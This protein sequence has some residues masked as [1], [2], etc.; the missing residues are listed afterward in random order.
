MRN[1]YREAL[2]T[3]L[4]WPLILLAILTATLALIAALL[5]AIERPRR[6]TFDGVFPFGFWLACLGITAA[7]HLREML[8]SPR[9]RVTPG[10]RETHLLVAGAMTAIVG[11]VAPCLI[12]GLT[13]GLGER[14]LAVAAVTLAALTVPAMLSQRPFSGSLRWLIWPLYLFVLFVLFR[15]E[16]P[17]D[18]PVS[19]MASVALFAASIGS[20]LAL[21]IHFLQLREETPGYS[22][23]GLL[24][25]LWGPGSAISGGRDQ[26]QLQWSTFRVRFPH[27]LR[28]LGGK[29]PGTGETLLR[30][31]LHWHAASQVG[32][33]ML[34]QGMFFGAI[35]PV[36][37][38]LLGTR[39]LT[40]SLGYVSDLICLAAPLVGLYPAFAI[41]LQPAVRARVAGEFLRPFSRSQHVQAVALVLIV[42][43]ASEALAIMLFPFAV[44]WL[45]A[46]KPVWSQQPLWPMATGLSA[47]PLFLGVGLAN[48]RESEVF[49]A[50][51]GSWI[52]YPLFLW[53]AAS[54]EGKG[55]GWPLFGLCAL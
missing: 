15:S 53:L 34:L 24:R 31:A 2:S 26:K 13:V 23:R 33:N 41:A 50:I 49:W 39:S 14:G 45:V 27:N 40:R 46:S 9:S 12:G 38:S 32:W 44:F 4:R 48:L 30:R 18:I 22:R 47:I 8:G 19:V 17:A 42:F 7:E 52:A 36:M 3:Y 11:F 29:S 1:R 5:L 55:E 43:L 54:C 20:L 10:L 28:A 6:I 37:G 16:G 35:V 51:L 21:A 25:P